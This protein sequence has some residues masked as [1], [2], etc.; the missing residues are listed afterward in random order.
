MIGVPKTID[1]DLEATAMTF[2]FD[3]AVACVGM[4]WIGSTR[5][6]P[7]TNASWCSK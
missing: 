7:A 3:S 1:N 6:P 4:P 5:Q 2:G